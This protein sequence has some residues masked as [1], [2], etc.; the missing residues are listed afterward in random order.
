M[1]TTSPT[2]LASRLPTMDLW[3]LS[4]GK[5]LFDLAC[6]LVAVAVASPIMIMLA[7][8]VKASSRGPF[9]FRQNRVGK[10]GDEFPVFK[11]RTMH[12]SDGNNS[13]PLI[14]RS[15]DQRVTSV[16]KW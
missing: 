9:L 12:S 6:A 3:S 1:Q 7:L 15:G 2:T 13:G 4:G 10:N 5:R 16:G 8:A 14:T 11:F